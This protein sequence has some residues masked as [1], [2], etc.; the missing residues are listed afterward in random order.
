MQQ[1]LE[2]MRDVNKL[3]PWMTDM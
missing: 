3:K 1:C 2:S